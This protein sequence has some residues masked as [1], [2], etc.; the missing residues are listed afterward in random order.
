MIF[1]YIFKCLVQKITDLFVEMIHICTITLENIIDEY[2]NKWC[3]IINEVQIPGAKVALSKHDEALISVNIDEI[4]GFADTK[5]QL[6]AH[7]Q[8]HTK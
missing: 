7:L 5:N 8:N 6:Y 2:S 1:I 4:G 3:T